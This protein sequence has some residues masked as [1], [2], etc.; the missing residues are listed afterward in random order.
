MGLLHDRCQPD[1]PVLGAR[2]RPPTNS[3]TDANI[4]SV[5][6]P[7]RSAPVEIARQHVKGRVQES[8]WS[9]S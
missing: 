8:V 6:S 5:H 3:R 7:A 2:R 9:I 1:M 4:G